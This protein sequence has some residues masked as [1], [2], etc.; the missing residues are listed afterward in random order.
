MPSSP[1][2]R[3]LPVIIAVVAVQVIVFA[4]VWRDARDAHLRDVPVAIVAPAIVADSLASESDALAGHPF[5][6]RVLTTPAGGRAQIRDGVIVA[7]LAVDLT[8]TTD[9]LFVGGAHGSTLVR[10][11]TDRILAIEK[12][13]GRTAVIEDLV[14]ARDHDENQR[15][16][17]ILV[18]LWTVLGFGLSAAIAFARGAQAPSR[19]R[20]LARLSGLSALAVIA[21][22]LGAVVAGSMYDGHL[23]PLWLL[24]TLTVFTSG[25]VTMGLQSLFGLAGI[26][27]GTVVLLMLAVP[28]FIATSPL[29]LPQPWP[30]IHPWVPHGAASSAFTSI[31]YFGGATA[32]KPI[33]VLGAWSVLS[34]GVMALSRHERDLATAALSPVGHTR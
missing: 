31:V 29:L 6:T 30:A 9:T 19:K 34:I 10:D 28:E 2:R 1:H 15:V 13:Q 7:A 3:A 27:V 21:G 25:A 14:P 23:V 12:S 4:L 17:R 11:V 33:L 26:G 5:E 18:L 32:L 20:S 24:G 8:S 16:G 22:L